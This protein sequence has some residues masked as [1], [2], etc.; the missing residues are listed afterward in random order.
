VKEMTSSRSWT[1]GNRKWRRRWED[2]GDEQQ[3]L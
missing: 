2:E 3:E 1:G